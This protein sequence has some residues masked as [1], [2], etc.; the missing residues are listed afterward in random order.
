M[1]GRL[2]SYTCRKHGAFTVN[3][4]CGYGYGPAPQQQQCP[5]PDCFRLGDRKRE[6]EARRQR[7][8]QRSIAI[9]T[10][11]YERLQKH[12]NAQGISMAQW[13]EAHTEDIGGGE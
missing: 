13:I 9:P 6:A 3:V 1:S 8:S 10:E 7:D 12:C 5:V 2:V 11:T 4:R